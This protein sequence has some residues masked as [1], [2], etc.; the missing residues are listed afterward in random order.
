MAEEARAISQPHALSV[1]TASESAGDPCASASRSDMRANQSL[2]P[3]VVYRDEEVV[4]VDKPS[5][6]A[7]QSDGHSGDSLVGWLD[8]KQYGVRTATFAPAPAHRAR[9]PT[10]LAYAA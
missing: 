2:R 4:V 1:R 10:C 7:M 6:L 8:Y 3:R 9:P 5:G